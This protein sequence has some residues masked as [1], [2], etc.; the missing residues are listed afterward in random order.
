MS[1][2]LSPSHRP[3]PFRQ[4][5]HPRVW[6]PSCF[7]DGP[8]GQLPRQPPPLPSGGTLAL[9]LLTLLPHWE[10]WRGAWA[11]PHLLRG[12][13]DGSDKGRGRP[14]RLWQRD[15]QAALQKEKSKLLA[16]GQWDPEDLEGTRTGFSTIPPSFCT[17]VTCTLLSY[18]RSHR[19]RLP[20]PLLK[21]CKSQ[22]FMEW[23]ATTE[24]EFSINQVL[25]YAICSWFCK[26]IF[27]SL[28]HLPF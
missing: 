4:P 16:C 14:P 2:C 13:S 25:V 23:L 7:Q 6:A 28:L 17:Q 27:I 22:F 10:W 18:N 3:S 24:K 20:L 15:L 12:G 9:E 5:R 21:T 26:V 19:R 8:S 11:G 1:N